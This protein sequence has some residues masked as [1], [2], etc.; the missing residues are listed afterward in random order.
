MGKSG[1]NKERSLER[2]NY[3]MRLSEKG[4][5]A[6]KPPIEQGKLWLVEQWKTKV[7]LYLGILIRLNRNLNT[8][9]ERTCRSGN[10]K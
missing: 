3:L 9:L 7:R 1:I 8:P 6:S 5:R 2:D 4:E 10:T